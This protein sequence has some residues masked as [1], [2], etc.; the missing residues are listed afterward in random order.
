MM[1][2][3]T[4]NAKFLREKKNLNPEVTDAMPGWFL[5]LLCGDPGFQML[6]ENMLESS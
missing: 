5:E 2:D 6:Y 4:T 3:Q 1:E